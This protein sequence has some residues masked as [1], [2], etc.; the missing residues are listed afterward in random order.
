MDDKHPGQVEDITAPGG[1]P[2]IANG[3]GIWLKRA[4]EANSA[5]TTYMESSVLNQWDDNIDNFRSRN[6]AKEGSKNRKKMFRPK[7]RSALRGHE[8]ALATALFSNNDLVAVG[9]SDKN[10]KLQ[11]VSAKINAALLQHRLEKTIPW[12]QTVLGAYQDTLVYGL[13]VSKCYWRYEP[14]PEENFV[15]RQGPDGQTELDAEGFELWELGPDEALVDKPVINLLSPENFRFD[16]NA[17]WR[18]PVEDSPYLIEHIPMY[19][20]DVMS[21]M[22]LSEANSKTGEPP[23]HTYSLAQILAA[24]LQ[25]ATD[26]KQTRD[27]REGD[28]ED[29]RDMGGP[30]E[31]TPV[32]V[33][34][35][36]YREEG[37]DMAYYTLGTTLMLSDPVPL[38]D[39]YKHGREVYTIGVSTIESHRNYP[40]ALTEL[41]G[42]IQREI[43]LLADQ[44]YDNVR[45]V[46]NKRYFIR[47][48]GNVDLAALRNNRPGGGIFVDNP[49]EDVNVIQTPDVTSSSYAEQDRLNQD[50]DELMGTFSPS[51]IQSNRAMNE[52]VGGMNLMSSG[53]NS[54]QE[55]IMRTFIETWVEPVL[56]TLAKLEQYFET[57]ETILS[58][59]ASKA[60]IP[61]R[62]TKNGPMMDRLIQQDLNITVNVGLGNTNP[63]QK[64]ERLMMAV[65]TAGNMPQM[66]ERT[67]W[68]E[69][70]KEIWAYA[71][72]GDGERFVMTKEK[73]KEGQQPAPPPEVMIKQAEMKARAEMEQA[74]QAHEMQ[75][76]QMRLQ[77]EGQQQIAEMNTRRELELIKLSETSGI[78]LE[79]LRAKMDIES[80]KNKTLREIEALKASLMSREFAIK[81]KMGSGI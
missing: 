19:A 51:S 61:Q 58:V 36:I 40:S 48:Q 15:P 47:R 3:D 8:A 32:W 21:R 66:G 6:D 65:N 35:N 70:A 73:Q 16:P 80:S 68:P 55:Y 44:R 11:A 25:S 64:L 39:I 26:N 62:S 18:N 56:R 2:A 71:G 41:G 34:F 67:D 72:F 28:R 12:Y 5:A 7:T 81:M 76:L 24:G 52:T 17:D 14:A 46:L 49:N 37:V 1:D 63:E 20:A 53:A 75:M 74:R 23:W 54:S 29:P 77:Q 42:N 78:K 43:N 45:L 13:V 79:E 60:E 59:A 33:H 50:M 31:F 30:S 4:A 38:T 57:D 27:A 10:N 69:V 9:P 22:A